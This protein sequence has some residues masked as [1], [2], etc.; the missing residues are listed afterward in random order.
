MNLLIDHVTVCGSDLEKMRQDFAGVGLH[1]TYGGCHANGVTHMDLLTFPDGS[2]IELIAPV[3]S[4]SAATGMMSGW[5]KLMEGN[6]GAGA[7]AVRTGD[8][9][10]EVT[11]LRNAGI[12][13]RGPEAGSRERPDGKKIEWETSIVGTGA[14]GS[15][16]PFLIEDKTPRTLR[17]PATAGA[18]VIEGVAAVV[19]AV[20]DLESSI[21][22]FRRA[23][24]LKKPIIKDHPEF[25]ATIAHFAGTPVMLAVPRNEKNWLGERIARFGESPAAFL[26]MTMDFSRGMSKFEV[27]DPTRWLGREVAWFDPQRL[28]GTRLGLIR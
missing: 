14:A 11:H 3:S 16:L 8:I 10:T 7:W 15:L 4:S 25:G 22:L 13:V 6:A 21:E 1:T 28:G 19:I 27:N 23:Y 20:R 5:A 9:K 12:E 2:Y 26:L 24:E 18:S 17:V